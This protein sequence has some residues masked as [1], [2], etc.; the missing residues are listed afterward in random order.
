MEIKFYPELKSLQVQY[1]PY[2]LD[3]QVLVAFSCFHKLK[4]HLK[5][6][7]LRQ[8][9]SQKKYDGVALHCV[10]RSDPVVLWLIENSLE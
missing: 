1:L 9:G 5:V 2:S 7:I 3:L 10:Q 4:I 6:N 8:G